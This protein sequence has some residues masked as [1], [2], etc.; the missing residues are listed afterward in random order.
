MVNG[1]TER[2]HRFKQKNKILRQQKNKS[3]YFSNLLFLTTLR[4]K[5]KSDCFVCS[6][7]QCPENLSG[8][9]KGLQ[10][11]CRKDGTQL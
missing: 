3:T 8:T 2:I 1:E 5:K 11:S 7:F 4:K 6:M 9:L 10:N